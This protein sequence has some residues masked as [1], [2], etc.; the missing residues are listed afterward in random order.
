ML[1]PGRHNHLQTKSIRAGKIFM[2]SPTV[3]PIPQMDQAHFSHEVHEL[4]PLSAVDL[5]LDGDRDGAVI[6]LWRQNEFVRKA[7]D[8]GRIEIEGSGKVNR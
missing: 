6:R 7:R 2:K 8:R 4:P 5:K 3:R 1:V